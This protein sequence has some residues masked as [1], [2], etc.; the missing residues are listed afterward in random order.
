MKKGS[1]ANPFLIALAKFLGW[2]GAVLLFRPRLYYMDP[3][4]QKRHIK[5]AAI[6]MSNH[7]AFLDF[8]LYQL[9]FLERNIRFL[10]AEIL[11]TKSPVMTWALNFMGCIRVNRE[12]VDLGFVEQALAELDRGKVVGVFPQGRLPVDGCFFPYKPGIVFIALHSDAPIIP[13]YTDGQYGFGKHAHVMIGSP[14]HIRKLCSTEN[15]SS[16]EIEKLTAYLQQ[17]T[18]ELKAELEKRMA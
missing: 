10:V 2:F 7:T 8:I 18:L 9:I 4:L 6:V 5:G 3:K 16:E 11:Y 12:G 15:P 13:I 14:I 1:K 17:V